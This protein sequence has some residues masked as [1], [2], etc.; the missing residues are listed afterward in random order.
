MHGLFYRGCLF[1]ADV[2]FFTSPAHVHFFLSLLLALLYLLSVSH[3]VLHPPHYQL[4]P[5]LGGIKDVMLGDAEAR[6][7]SVGGGALRK[8]RLER[9]GTPTFNILVELRSYTEMI[10]WPDVAA[11]VDDL[12]ANRQPLMQVRYK[13]NGAMWMR[14]EPDTRHHN[15]G[16]ANS[17]AGASFLDALARALATPAKQ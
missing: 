8:V 14:L 15:A 2:S 9:A 10:V 3:T 12:L 1:P 6:R 13:H 4:V 5:L 17:A 11:A 7:A 16:N